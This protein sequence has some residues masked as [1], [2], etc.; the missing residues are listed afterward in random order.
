MK[1]EHIIAIVVVVVVIVVL[2]FFAPS[3]KGGEPTPM[4]TDRT[5]PYEEL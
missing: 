1:R 3:C 4:D 2:V 5:D